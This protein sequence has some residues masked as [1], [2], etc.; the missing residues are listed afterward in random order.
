MLGYLGR[1][2]V[3]K[4]VISWFLGYRCILR[5]HS[6]KYQWHRFALWEAEMCCSLKAAALSRFGCCCRNNSSPGDCSMTT[7][8]GTQISGS[9]FPALFIRYEVLERGCNRM[10]CWSLLPSKGL[11]WPKPRK[12]RCI[13]HF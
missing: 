12:Y 11:E 3:L 9:V 8:E 1:S 6:S 5:V 2:E 4:G 10:R 7:G 13:L